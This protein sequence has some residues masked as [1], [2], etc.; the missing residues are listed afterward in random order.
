MQPDTAG[1]LLSEM[2]RLTNGY[3][4][5]GVYMWGLHIFQREV[6]VSPSAYRRG[7]RALERPNEPL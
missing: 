3:A 2:R 1:D 7:R 5:L 4:R 6:G